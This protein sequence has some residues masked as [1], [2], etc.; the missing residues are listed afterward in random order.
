[1]GLRLGGETGGVPGPAVEEA[2][3]S[4]SLSKSSLGFS[5]SLVPASPGSVGCSLLMCV[6]FIHHCVWMILKKVLNSCCIS[7]VKV[8]CVPT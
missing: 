4:R 7:K 8:V 6:H 3:I 5:C 1:M 2:S